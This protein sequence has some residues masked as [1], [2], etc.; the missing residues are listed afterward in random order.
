MG[1]PVNGVSLG[2]SVHSQSS[3]GLLGGRGKDSSGVVEGSV[4][5]GEV[6]DVEFSR[7]GHGSGGMGVGGNADTVGGG[8]GGDRTGLEDGLVFGVGV[9]V[10][11]LIIVVVLAL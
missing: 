9:V 2:A 1:R 5:E 8:V 11:L 10:L 7:L 4:V 6:P 3:G